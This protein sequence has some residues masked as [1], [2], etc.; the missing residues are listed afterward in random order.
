MA[1][2]GSL[3]V[4]D[5]RERSAKMNP[6]GVNDMGKRKRKL[7]AAEKAEKRRRRR[8]FMTVFINGKMK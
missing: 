3:D 1:L 8:E 2:A 7:T 4:L 6:H 5:M